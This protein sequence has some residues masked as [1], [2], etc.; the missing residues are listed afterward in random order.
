MAASQVEESAQP[1]LRVSSVTVAIPVLNGAAY[2]DE[3][4]G[5][6]RRQRVEVPVEV[7]VVDSGSSDGSVEIARRH[8][9]RVIEIPR[10]EFSHGGTRNLAVAEATGDVVVFLTQDATPASEQ[11]LASMAEGFEQADDI[12]LVFGPHIPRPGHS[13]VFAREMRDHFRTWGDGERIDAHRLGRSPEALAEY[14]R[15]PYKLQFFSDVNGGIAR[16]AWQQIPYREVSYA[17][18]QLLGREM[19]ESGHAKVFH[20]AGS[21]DATSTSSGACARCW[22]TS[23]RSGSSMRRAPS[24]TR[25]DWIA[26]S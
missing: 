19:I 10:A 25:L 6:V 23:S 1:P 12:A 11:W 17:E 4:L 7:L 26:T 5:A 16:W 3:V 14:R 8:G 21:C 18:D 2:L 22:G 24:T 20:R 13:H 15:Y 9:A